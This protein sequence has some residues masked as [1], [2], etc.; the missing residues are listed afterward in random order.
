MVPGAN[1]W[2]KDASSHVSISSERTDGRF[3]H[4]GRLVAGTQVGERV[5]HQAGVLGTQKGQAV[6]LREFL[7]SWGGL[8]FL[9]TSLLLST[10]MYLVDHTELR[11]DCLHNH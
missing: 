2:W 7:E 10:S 1:G 3:L 6:E 4:R 5:R 9:H 11:W 8:S